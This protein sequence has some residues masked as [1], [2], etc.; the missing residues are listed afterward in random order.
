MEYLGY[1]ALFTLL[2]MVGYAI[3]VGFAA[4]EVQ[5]EVEEVKTKLLLTESEVKKLT[6][7]KLLELAESLSVSVDPKSTKVTIVKEIEKVRN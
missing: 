6:K 1:V 4:T 5:D 3:W 2:A 7:P